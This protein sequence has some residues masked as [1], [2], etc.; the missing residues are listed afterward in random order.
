M[1]PPWV[2]ETDQRVEERG[3]TERMREGAEA[4]RWS[5]CIGYAV[6]ISELLPES[7]RCMLMLMSS[8][9]GGYCKM[10]DVSTTITC[11]IKAKARER[12]Y[13]VD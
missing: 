1:R 12:T 3:G 13:V 9:A 4:R 6:G 10:H 2:H 11:V 8:G 7:Y 5:Q